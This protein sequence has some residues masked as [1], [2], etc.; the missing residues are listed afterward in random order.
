MKTP[1]YNTFTHVRPIVQGDLN[2]L[3]MTRKGKSKKRNR[4]N[5]STGDSAE[6]DSKRAKSVSEL[7]NSNSGSDSCGPSSSVKNDNSPQTKQIA[8]TPRERLSF[9]ESDE[10]SITPVIQEDTPVWARD[11]IAA[12]N[13]LKS[14]LNKV[15]ETAS[16]TQRALDGIIK[17]NLDLS[18]QLTSLVDRVVK[19]E[20]DTT[21]LKSENVDLRERLLLNEFHQ[22]RN[23]LI[24]D[25]IP[26]VD[27]SESGYDCYMKVIQCVSNIPTVD[28]NHIR[29]D[30]CHRLGA[31]SKFK[32]RPIIAKF[33]WYGDLVSVMS[34]RSQLPS[35]VYVSEDL[36]DEWLERRK[37]LRPI[38]QKAKE[39][40]QFRNSSFLTRDKLIIKGKSYTVAPFNNLKD[41]PKEIVPAE[42]CER[43]DANTIAFLG[44]HSVYSNFHPASFTDG[45]VRYNCAEQM[46][47][48][49]KSALFGDT[50]TLQQVMCTSNP[51]Q[52]K[53]LGA[54]VQGFDR[55][56]WQQESKSIVKRAVTAKFTQNKNLAGIL[57]S[58]GTLLIV[59]ASA[60]RFWGTGIP[61]RSNDVLVREKWKGEGQ[62]SEILK[63]VRSLVS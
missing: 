41:L 59:E 52:M 45:G 53:Q 30:R 17:G 9:E 40:P 36:P 34:G 29:I 23:N 43:R 35:G 28:V 51:Y 44:P 56:T 49:E 37:L 14:D 33:N 2:A 61:L 42:A 58:T 25:G 32:P 1:V 18:T 48:A 54:R 50:V 63:Y 6:M 12:V 31:A 57:R 13:G 7:L 26:E 46:I 16:N 8:V 11:W 21:S 10:K 3:K 20:R 19:L 5:N 47:Q 4:S 39:L 55:E 62:M 27:G 24:F 60:D 22:R 38:L 15:S